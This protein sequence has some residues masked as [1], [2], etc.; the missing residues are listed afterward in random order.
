MRP[1]I[2]GYLVTVMA[3]SLL[4]LTAQR[5]A[6]KCDDAGVVARAR[7]AVDDACHCDSFTNHGKYVSCVAQAA[8]TALHDTNPSCQGAVVKCA[9]RSTCGKPGFV[10]CCRTSATGATKCSTKSSAD[11]CKAPPNGGTACVAVGVPSCCDACLPGG[12]CA[13]SPSGAFLDGTF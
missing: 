1:R 11:H 12:G 8:K 2:R 10:T 3:L 6:A 13:S 5:S 4:G 9:A 7:E